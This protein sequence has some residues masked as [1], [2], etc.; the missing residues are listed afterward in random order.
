MVE[1][2]Q[3]V[4]GLLLKGPACVN[5]LPTVHQAGEDEQEVAGSIHRTAESSKFPFLLQKS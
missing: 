5:H 1:T 3:Q 2:A 4:T